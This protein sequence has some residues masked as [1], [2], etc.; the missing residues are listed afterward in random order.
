[1]TLYDV[2]APAK[3]NLFL[4][5]VGR[6][7]DG[8][9]LLQTAF[10]FIDLCDVLH[11]EK[12]SDGR[13]VCEG[14]NPDLA[15]EDDLVVR[16]ARA[17]QRATGTPYGAQISYRKNIPSG[18]GLGGGSS[19]AATTLLALNRL[20][21][22][23][24]NRR[25]L[26]ALA[27]PLGA[28][29]PVFIFGQPAFA[30]GIGEILSPLTLPERAYVVIQPRQQVPTAGVFSAPELTRNSPSVRITVFADWQKVE[31][32]KEGLLAACVFDEKT[33]GAVRNTGYFGRND[34]EPVVCSRYPRVREAALRLGQLGI[35][36]RMTGS[37]A[38]FF[39]EF[40]TLEQARLCQQEIVV[41]IPCSNSGKEAV[42]ENTW[43]C[44][45]LLDHPLRYW[46]HS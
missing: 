42:I 27:L 38:C 20:W 35:D 15:H 32:K 37:G 34:L 25:E 13:I 7:D 44:P 31:A 45:G 21:Q 39:V 36:A 5:V 17:L 24:L 22:T 26:M 12:R 8:Y 30:E 19:D 33:A 9:H 46:V 10:R 43:A 16:A 4:H 23:G 3:L 40:V 11:Y 41:K 29:V 14:P 28:D 2:P 18:A 1:M 6:R